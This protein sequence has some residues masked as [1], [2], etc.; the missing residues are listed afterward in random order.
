VFEAFLFS[1]VTN[2]WDVLP[3]NQLPDGTF[4][5]LQYDLIHHEIQ[6]SFLEECIPSR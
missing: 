4:Q 5:H 6:K 2:V 1:A 3:Q